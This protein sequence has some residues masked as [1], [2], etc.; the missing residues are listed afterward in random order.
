MSG[1]TVRPCESNDLAAMLAITN[2][3]IAENFAH[4]GTTPITLAELK[5][6]F[7]SRGKYPWV[8]AT[9][10]APA[11]PGPV[12]GFAKAGPWKSRGAYAWSTEIGVYVRRDFHGRGIGGALYSV[13]FPA[14]EAAGLRCV[15]AGIALPNPASVRLH[16]KFGMKHVG[17]LEKVGYKFGA[18]R[19]VGYWQRLLGDG[20]PR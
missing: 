19:D 17:T 1:V 2:R 7:Q 8:V 6:D 4:F 14:I 9:A 11:E 15:M 20:P 16:E 13:L 5:A 3:E 18:W 10:S 12:V